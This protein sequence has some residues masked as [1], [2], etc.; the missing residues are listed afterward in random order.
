MALSFNSQ[1]N[2]HHSEAKDV[3]YRYL[4]NGIDKHFNSDLFITLVQTALISLYQ[5]NL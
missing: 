2:N 4:K 3:L 5:V 1:E